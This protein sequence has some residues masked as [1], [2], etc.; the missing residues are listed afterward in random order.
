MSREKSK[1][2]AA[3]DAASRG[4]DPQWMHDDRAN[5]SQFLQEETKRLQGKSVQSSRRALGRLNDATDMAADNLN[6]MNQQSE[7]L[8]KMEHTLEET[9]HTA[10]VNEQKVSALKSLNKFFLLPAFGVLTN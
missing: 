10:K 2:A 9:K 6:R 4:D 7:Q 1:W 3:A 5:N 8:Y